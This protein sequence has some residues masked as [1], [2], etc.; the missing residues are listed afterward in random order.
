M[1][2]I[3][4]LGSLFMNDKSDKYLLKVFLL[5]ITCIN[6]LQ[7]S[8]TELLPDEAYYYMYSTRLAWGYFDHPPMIALLIKL[9]E[10]FTHSELGVRLSSVLLNTGTAY[11]LY[12]LAAPKNI[13]KFIFIYFNFI[14]FQALGFL[15]V[16]DI[17]L[18]FFTA[19]FLLAFKAF[20]ETQNMQNI[21][22][23]GLCSAC[24]IYSKYHGF[25]VIGFA[26]LSNLSLLKK[27]ATYLL[28]IL[29]IA[30]LSPHIFWQIQN[31]FPSIKYHL[32]Y[33][34]DGGVK[35]DN[36]FGYFG[37]QLAFIGPVGAYLLT[38]INFKLKDTSVLHRANLFVALGFLLFFFVASFNGRIEAN[39]TAAAFIP[40]IVLANEAS[41]KFSLKL[42]KFAAIIT[43]V[44]ILP[45]RLYLMIN[46][47]PSEVN[48]K[49]QRHGWKDWA[50]KIKAK[51][52]GE[53]VIFQDSYQKASMY[54]FYA[55]SFAHS[56]NSFGL[57][58]NQFDVWS[59]MELQVQ[60]KPALV[61]PNWETDMFDSINN[62][63]VFK[64]IS[65][66]YY[67]RYYCYTKAEF[68]FEEA[69]YAAKQ[70]D[71]LRLKMCV[72]APEY[73]YKNIDEEPT[74]TT[75]L[76]YRIFYLDKDSTA[77]FYIPYQMKNYLTRKNKMN[78]KE[79][80]IAN[81]ALTK[82]NYKLIFFGK[83][84]TLGIGICKPIDIEVK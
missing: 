45:L 21:A 60:G 13:T 79:V 8:F 25:L 29:S 30:I 58:K 47:L 43:F 49:F 11:L 64:S 55:E 16:P 28:A 61:F 52:K 65:C 22:V 53:H 35:A 18:M 15:A 69:K 39:W 2:F 75:Q 1:D 38:K 34:F 62:T 63:K 76:G 70:G 46:F 78:F 56:P 51:A 67:N 66:L 80:L 44:L 59:D 48:Y 9:T 32:A 73:V 23:L 36:V 5:V 17:P 26:F 37:G 74:L 83:T 6:L 20:S 4:V 84:G 82:G 57:R 77:D 71:T 41:E 31:E 81:N 12:L 3:K 24:L 54:T 50:E 7:G 19:S 10:I 42:L 14:A 68:H 27:P 40:F 72:V 33:R